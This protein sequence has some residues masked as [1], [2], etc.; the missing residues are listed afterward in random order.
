MRRIY[1]DINSG[2]I[3][4]DRVLKLDGYGDSSVESDFEVYQVLIDRSSES[5]GLLE[6]DNRHDR[7][8]EICLDYK[9]NVETR[10]LE[11]IYRDPN[12][13]STPPN[14]LYQK[15]LSEQVNDNTEYLIDVDY[16]LSLIELG[17]N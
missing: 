2:L 14:P 9:V 15:P 4:L 11:F 17:L 12:N 8:I 16:R 5:V 10:E 1:Y 7:D 6:I 13:P 3:L